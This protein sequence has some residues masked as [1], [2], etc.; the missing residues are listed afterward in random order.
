MKDGNKGNI[1]EL[2]KKSLISQ[3]K[4]SEILNEQLKVEIRRKVSKKKDISIWWVPMSI[5]ILTSIILSSM[6][7]LFIPN[8]FIKISVIGVT[9]LVLIFNISLTTIGFKHFELKKGAIINI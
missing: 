2:L 5:S 8:L 3:E 1:E 6:A 4:P 9:L 7:Y